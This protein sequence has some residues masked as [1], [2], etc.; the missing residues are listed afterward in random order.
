MRHS[1]PVNVALLLRVASCPKEQYTLITTADQDELS[2][3][4]RYRP[5]ALDAALR[6]VEELRREAG[7]AYIAQLMESSRRD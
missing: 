4:L 7:K 6:R 3:L 5:A 1:S 2:Q